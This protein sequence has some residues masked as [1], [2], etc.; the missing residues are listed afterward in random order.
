M[1]V[2]GVMRNS[3][4][5]LRRKPGCL[6]LLALAVALIIAQLALLLWY[7]GA[8]DVW[9]FS[10]AGIYSSPWAQCHSRNFCSLESCFDFARC[11]PDP[12]QFRVHIY[13]DAADSPA[14]RIGAS[15]D[16]TRDLH[17][18]ILAAVR[19]SGFWTPN[20]AEACLLV[21][22]FD[23]LCHGRCGFVDNPYTRMRRGHTGP[24]GQLQLSHLLESLPHWPADANRSVG[25]GSNHV[26]FELHD[27]EAIGMVRGNAIL[28][29][30]GL[31]VQTFRYLHC[32][33]AVATCCSF[34]LYA[35]RD[36]AQA[37]L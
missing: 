16:D 24:A 4:S 15:R 3:L 10:S 25:A 20:A 2:R 33:L 28:I 6:A 32:L 19:R 21:P 7:L 5:L 30:S 26:L 34:L 31:S 17:R 27:D 29:K 11:P 36:M 9:R 13:G 22:D 14:D 8:M 37:G 12:S 35:W 23:T 1:I 18:A